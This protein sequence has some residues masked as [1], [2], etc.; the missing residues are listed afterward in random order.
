MPK[1]VVGPTHPPIQYVQ[2]FLS[3]G[4]KQSGYDA[5]HSSPSSAEIKNES[6]YNF[7]PPY[8]LMACVEKLCYTQWNVE[9]E[10]RVTN[11]PDLHFMTSGT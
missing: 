5:E 6:G 3:W 9:C 11:F 2:G 8:A 4:M 1:L 7:A 10:T